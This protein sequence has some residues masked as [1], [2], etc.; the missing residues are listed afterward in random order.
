MTIK[1]VFGLSALDNTFITKGIEKEFPNRADARIV[2]VAVKAFI[3]FLVALPVL[4]LLAIASPSLIGVSIV[5]AIAL[6]AITAYC[7]WEISPIGDKAASFLEKVQ[8]P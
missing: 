2:K 1:N 6:A 3:T 7:A 8:L 4:S 5:G